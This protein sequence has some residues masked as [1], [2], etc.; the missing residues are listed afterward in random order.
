MLLNDLL[1]HDCPLVPNIYL[2]FSAI[3]SYTLLSRHDLSIVYSHSPP[4]IP[5]HPFPLHHPHISYFPS[6]CAHHPPHRQLFPQPLLI[7][8]YRFWWTVNSLRLKNCNSCFH[9]AWGFHS[10]EQNVF[11]WCCNTF[12]YTRKSLYRHPACFERHHP[13]T[14]RL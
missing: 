2:L 1:N 9:S 8:V 13:V 5:H 3:S 4:S 6:A 12:Q 7:E 11:F 14:T 10:S